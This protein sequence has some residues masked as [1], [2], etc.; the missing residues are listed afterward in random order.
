MNKSIKIFL[1]WFV[2]P[3]LAIWLF[4]SLYRQVKDQPDLE[5]AIA[6]IRAAPFGEQA[7]KFW[8][9][10]VMVFINWGLE[11][12]KW[13]LLMRSIQPMSFLTAFKSVLCGVTMSL[14][15]P[16]RIGEYAG[17]VLFVKEGH[18]LQAVSLSVAG[19]IAQLIITMIMGCAGLAYLLFSKEHN[20]ALMGISA[21]WLQLFLYGSIFATVLF[22]FFF[23]RMG[24]LI[25]LLEKLPYSDRFAKYIHV[26]ET[27]D[28]KILLRLLF[29]S[30]LRYVVFV[31]QYIFMLQVMQVEQNYWPGFWLTSVMFWIMAIIPSFAIAELGIR[32]TVAKTLFA[33]SLN[34]IGILA[35]TFHIWFVNLFVPALTGSLLILGLKL[36]KEK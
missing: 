33:Y 36:K 27:F 34:T 23:F 11:A 4:Y 3:L 8:I 20:S 26:L 29:L 15:T 35:V 21:F 18:R 12:R 24:W 31:L 22:L 19:G 25:R 32:G 7:W 14:N 17:R 9:V 16:N 1:K 30:F 2:G 6:L 5:T 28:A 10:L 13:Q